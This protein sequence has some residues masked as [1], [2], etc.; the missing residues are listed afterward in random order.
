D[1]TLR[2][3]VPLDF[4]RQ[5]FHLITVATTDVYGNSIEKVTQVR[6]GDAF[7]PVVETLPPPTDNS[8]EM[9]L[10][11]GD[12]LDEGTTQGVTERGFVL[13]FRPDPQ[14]GNSSSLVLR[15]GAGGGPFEVTPRDLSP[16]KKYFYRAFASNSEGVGYGTQESFV[17][18]REA[19]VSAWANAKPVAQ[20][21]GWWSSPWFGNFFLAG[22]GWI[23]H[24]S[25]GWMYPA[26]A[27][28]NGIW[29]WQ[30]ELGWA[31]TNRGI[32]PYL[33]VQRDSSWHYFFG[34]VDGRVVLYRYAD[35]EWL[36]L[37]EGK[38][39]E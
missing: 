7:T 9:H 27:S 25:L 21:L 20:A 2:T 28:G 39:G 33:Y 8:K 4:E 24:E 12:V 30:E 15:V 5:E 17:V 19:V 37:S 29:L 11:S 16:G 26:P 23:N 13:S 14:V 18:P 32:F 34:R 10:L 22:N 1:G 36:D 31:W 3:R 38:G 35:N 6:V